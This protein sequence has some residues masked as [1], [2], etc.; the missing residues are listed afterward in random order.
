MKL[1][2]HTVE[3]EASTR[4]Q[5]RKE[6]FENLT[7]RRGLCDGAVDVDLPFIDIEIVVPT[8]SR[9]PQC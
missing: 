4:L 1:P 9:Y 8:A 6:Q 5:T 7:F 3:G 2:F